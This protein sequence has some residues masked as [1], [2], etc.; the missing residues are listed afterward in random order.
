MRRHAPKELLPWDIRCL[1]Q[2][3]VTAT[4]FLKKE[5][6]SAS[7]IGIGSTLTAARR[8]R[9]AGNANAFI[10]SLC[11]LSAMAFGIAAG[12]YG[13]C[14]EWIHG[15]AFKS[16]LDHGRDIGERSGTRRRTDCEWDELAVTD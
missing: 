11:S 3:Q 12:R 6:N 16:G 13:A 2:L 8:S 15:V 7:V 4:S 14:V 9:T 10:I 5:P 1:H